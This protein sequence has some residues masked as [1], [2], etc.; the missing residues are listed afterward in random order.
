MTH[1]EKF[2][3]KGYP[4]GIAGEDIPLVGRISAIADVFDALTSP[5][6]Y[7]KAW[8]TE[9]AF[10]LL[11]DEKGEHFDPKLVDIFLEHK[12]EILEIKE[13]LSDL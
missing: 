5:R 11:I 6:P 9:D 2:N 3:G 1:H 12:Q 13:R 8:D 7:K 10:Q 4:A